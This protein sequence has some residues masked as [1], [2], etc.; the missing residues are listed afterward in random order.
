MSDAE[1]VKQLT[2]RIEEATARVQADGAAVASIDSGKHA[3][4][5][6]MAQLQLVCDRLALIAAGAV[7]SSQR[8]IIKE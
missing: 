1:S 4:S 2:S 5:T 8:K 7:V 6:Q 3:L